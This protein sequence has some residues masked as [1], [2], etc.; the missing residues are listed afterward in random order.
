MKFLSDSYAAI[1]ALLWTGRE[2]RAKMFTLQ[3]FFEK[4]PEKCGL[5]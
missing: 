1:W 4:N 5:Y 2:I 3:L